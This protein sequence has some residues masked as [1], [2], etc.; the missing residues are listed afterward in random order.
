MVPGRAFAV[1]TSAETQFCSALADRVGCQSY[2]AFL[3][4][5]RAHMAMIPTQYRKM[6]YDIVSA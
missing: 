3:V 1:K 4:S 5:Y 2:Q 6:K